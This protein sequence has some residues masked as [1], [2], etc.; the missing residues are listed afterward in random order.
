MG[1]S[2]APADKNSNVQLL[3]ERSWLDIPSLYTDNRRAILAMQKGSVGERVFREA[4]AAWSA[5]DVDVSAVPAK[6]RPAPP[7]EP[8]PPA[9]EPAPSGP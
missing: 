5:D 2:A 7:P 1:L 4:F 8:D 3:K 6:A 9:A